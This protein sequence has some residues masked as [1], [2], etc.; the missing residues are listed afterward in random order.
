MGNFLYNVHKS[1]EEWLKTPRPIPKRARQ[2]NAEAHEKANK[3]ANK[4]TNKETDKEVDAKLVF[5]I[6]P[7]K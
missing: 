4:E 5:S 6:S 2:L 7:S 3:E 1:R